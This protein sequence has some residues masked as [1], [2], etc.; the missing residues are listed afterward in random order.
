[1]KR[2]L[3]RYLKKKRGGGG[4]DR[5]GRRRGKDR[6]R[7]GESVSERSVSFAKKRIQRFCTKKFN[8]KLFIQIIN[9]KHLQ[10]KKN[11]IK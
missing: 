2:I 4:K 10:V 8:C 6:G 5:K 3:E 7:E 9:Y 11:K 1:M